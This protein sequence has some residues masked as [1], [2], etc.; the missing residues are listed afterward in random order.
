MM[1]VWYLSCLF[2]ALGGL[3]F[4]DWRRHLVLWNKSTS[5]SSSAFIL[6]RGL[7][8][9]GLGVAYFSL[10]DV[11]G[12]NLR[13]FSPGASFYD[14]GLLIVPGYPIEELFFL[15]LL[16]YQALVAWRLVK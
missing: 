4:I 6:R 12:I 7:L 14:L 9:V 16:C 10:W 8:A 11:I 15:T 5:S 3:G 13:I 2:V 1:H